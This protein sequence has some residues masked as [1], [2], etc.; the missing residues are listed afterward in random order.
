M[1]ADEKLKKINAA[2]DLIYKAM[3]DIATA[4]WKMAQCGISIEM[5][6][7]SDYEMTNRAYGD[8]NVILR[9]GIKTLEEITVEGG[10][11]NGVDKR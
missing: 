7:H 4:R 6:L 10:L 1:T 5:G 11:K 8:P 3:Q 9:D 2:C